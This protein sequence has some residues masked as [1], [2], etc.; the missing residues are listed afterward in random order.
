[1]PTGA[2]H[3]TVMPGLDIMLGNSETIGLALIHVG[4]PRTGPA[5]SEDSATL[6]ITV[7]RD[8]L[9]TLL[10]DNPTA[11]RL[12]QSQ[13][14]R[15]NAVVI[16]VRSPQ[17]VSRIADDIRRTTYSGTGRILFL[18]S[19]VLELLA[20][21]M[22]TPEVQA[23]RDLA[24]QI[25]DLLMADPQNPPEIA[26]LSRR[27]GVSPRKLNERFRAAFGVTLSDWR[28]DWRLNRARALLADSTLSIREISER[29]GYGAVSNFTNA[30][31][32]RFGM[33]PARY[34]SRGL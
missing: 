14:M 4:G 27:L 13:A 33:P 9:C 5:D 6:E 31:T 3:M 7:A 26:E 21:G 34:R 20:E 15:D 18:Q 23:K 1:M 32:K 17:V 8:V 11:F 19:K 22:V 25:E 12:I 2:A 16:P 24:G 30:F 28:V 29:L 10:G